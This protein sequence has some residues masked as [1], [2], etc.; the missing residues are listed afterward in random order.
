MTM[1]LFRM[2]EI[3]GG[4]IFIDGQ[5]ISKLGLHTLRRALSIIPQDPVMFTGSL[6]DNL[7]PFRERDEKDVWHALRTVQLADW[8]R[9]DSAGL[10]LHV[11]EGG[12]NMSVGQRQLVCLARALLRKPSI[13]ILDE[14]T[15]SVDYETDR[16][17]QDAI[18]L[19]F[20][21]TSMTIAHRLN[22]VMDTDQIVVMDS[23][24]VAEQGAPAT[25]LDET[26]YLSGM[27]NS[28][29]ENEAAYLTALARGETVFTPPSS[30]K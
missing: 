4:T 20:T 13:L 24:H 26:G 23:G 29:G 6:W 18:R 7:D 19:R 9:S 12:G 30:L 11:S 5:D 25:L 28:L 10:D 3:C 15:A 22:T 8:A 14:A 1:V 27:I 21:G 16:L 2:V 17:I